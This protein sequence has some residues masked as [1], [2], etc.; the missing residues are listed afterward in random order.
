MATLY[1]IATPIGNLQDITLRALR[2]LKEEV[3]WIACEDTRHSQRLLQEF[4]ISARVVSYH[5]HNEASRTAELLRHLAEGNNIALISDA[6]TPLVSDPGFRLVQ[7]A[8]AAGFPVVPIPGASAVICAL[9]A[10][11]LPTDQFYF[12]GFL[13]PKTHGRTKMLEAVA[14]LPATLIFYEA[15]H[16]LLESLA[17]VEAVLGNR[18]VVVARE[19]TKL[20]E[21]FAR[22]RVAEVRAHFAAREEVRGEITLLI[23]GTP[24]EDAAPPDVP[25]LLRQRLAAGA[26]KMEAVKHVAKL[27]NL[28]KREVYRIAEELPEQPTS[29]PDEATS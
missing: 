16:R 1:L 11:G 21:E 8:I 7:G 6:G 28:P 12:G 25:Q 29:E 27:L 10:S 18:E 13:A 5:D 24:A 3:Q 4:G 20:H 22:G 23:S 14:S 26:S 15:P 9:A 2:I 19:M 17:D